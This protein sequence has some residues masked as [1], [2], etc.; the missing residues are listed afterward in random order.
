MNDELSAYYTVV[1]KIHK[2]GYT[3]ESVQE[4]IRQ[5]HSKY[6]GLSDINECL[7]LTV[8]QYF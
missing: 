7:R 8:S 1:D 3:N 6:D 4:E 5:F 2:A